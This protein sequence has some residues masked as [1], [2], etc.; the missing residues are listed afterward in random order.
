LQDKSAQQNYGERISKLL[1]HDY[2]LGQ[3][4]VLS[5]G[6]LA[7]RDYFSLV[8][9]GSNSGCSD[10]RLWRYLQPDRATHMRDEAFADLKQALEDASPLSVE[11]VEN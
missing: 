5:D 11:N 7:E 2:S 3:G 10:A 9:A 1:D 6:I 4:F 8:S